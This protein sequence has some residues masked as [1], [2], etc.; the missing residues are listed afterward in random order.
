MHLHN[1]Y[2]KYN[3]GFNIV[4]AGRYTI[5]KHFVRNS[6]CAIL[7]VAHR[8]SPVDRPP[9]T[10][11]RPPSTVHRPPSTVDRRESPSMWLI[12]WP[13]AVFFCNEIEASNKICKNNTVFLSSSYVNFPIIIRSEMEQYEIL[14]I[15]L[16]SE[17]LCSDD[18]GVKSELKV[19]D[20]VVFIFESNVSIQ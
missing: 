15:I 2:Q 6:I 18:L 13:S 16:L 3:T 14:Y 12:N 11:H 10:V 7:N 4:L 17:W 19:V 5:M 1:I 9:S 8:T 20:F